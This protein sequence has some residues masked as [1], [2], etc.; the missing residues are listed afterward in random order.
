MNGKEGIRFW[1]WDLSNV[2]LRI[3]QVLIPVTFSPEFPD[4]F[5]RDYLKDRVYSG[6]KESLE[7]LEDAIRLEVQNIPVTMCENVVEHFRIRIQP[8]IDSLSIHRFDSYPSMPEANIRKIS[9]S[10]PD[11]L[12]SIHFRSIISFFECHLI[13]K[14]SLPIDCHWFSQ[15]FQ[16]WDRKE[17]E[18]RYGTSVRETSKQ[19][20]TFGANR[21]QICKPVP[22]LCYFQKGRNF[23]PH[24]VSR[25]YPDECWSKVSWGTREHSEG[26]NSE[27]Y[28]NYMQTCKGIVEIQ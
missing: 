1:I 27:E 4:F 8:S 13:K 10:K 15:Y 23:V 11:T 6:R 2:R 17:S 21:T 12:F 18:L 28:T 20:T 24:P 7:V 3:R 9:Y 25:N 22:E 19:D 5:L 16:N 14:I 26:K